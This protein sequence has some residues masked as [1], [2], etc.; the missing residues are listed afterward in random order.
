MC[1]YL[2][3]AGALYLASPAGDRRF[4][5]DEARGWRV[6]GEEAI[7]EQR[8]Q[9]R[10]VRPPRGVRVYD[11]CR[12]CDPVLIR[13]EGAS[14]VGDIVAEHDLF[15]EFSL[16]FPPGEPLRVERTSGPR[17]AMKQDLRARGLCVL[18]ENEP[19]AIAHRE[20]KAARDRSPRHER[21]R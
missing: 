17:D 20:V 5:D 15:V 2:V 3:H 12:E 1:T 14:L 18:D 9:L 13:T 7:S 8:F 4:Q 10:A 16:T 19:L 6:R 21:W 11:H